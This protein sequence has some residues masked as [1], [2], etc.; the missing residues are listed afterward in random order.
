MQDF[1]FRSV[2]PAAIAHYATGLRERCA[3]AGVVL[4]RDWQL[5]ALL[6]PLAIWFLVFLYKPMLGL[7]IAFKDY[8]LFLGLSGSPWIGF[9]N[10][11]SLLADDQFMRAIR[12]ARPEK[13]RSR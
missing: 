12:K 2:V 1:G 8:S 11:W 13:M 5:Y 10:F 3:G 7:R 9:E 6:A 4:R